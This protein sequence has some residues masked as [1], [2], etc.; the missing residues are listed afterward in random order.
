MQT[1]C[2]RQMSGCTWGVAATQNQ[3]CQSLGLAGAVQHRRCPG[4]PVLP[5]LSL[6]SSGTCGESGQRLLISS[7]PAMAFGC[8]VPMHG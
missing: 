2:Q 1:P 4:T 6:L 8:M 3:H 7:G 5:K